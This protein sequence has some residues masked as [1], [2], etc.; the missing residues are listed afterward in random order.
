MSLVCA[1]QTFNRG[2]FKSVKMNDFLNELALHRTREGKKTSSR[3]TVGD[4]RL[5]ETVA[6]VNSEMELLIRMIMA[7]LQMA[8]MQSQPGMVV[9]ESV[10]FVMRYNLTNGVKLWFLGSKAKDPTMKAGPGAKVSQIVHADGHQ[11]S[12]WAF[13]VRIGSSSPSH[14]K[15]EAIIHRPGPDID[16]KHWHGPKQQ[17]H[18]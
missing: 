17:T 4:S 15:V 8:M 11:P 13:K 16:S 2:S 10:V 18:K 12:P 3:G 7:Q 6:L 1:K 5:K 9:V 14:V